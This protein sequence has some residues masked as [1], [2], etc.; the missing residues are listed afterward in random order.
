MRE[1]DCGGKQ[2]NGEFYLRLFLSPARRNDRRTHWRRHWNS[3]HIF[4]HPFSVIPETKPIAYFFS[5]CEWSRENKN[6]R[7]VVASDKTT[8]S[9][10]RG[11][12]C[13][14][15]QG[16]EIVIG[17]CGDRIEEYAGLRKVKKYKTADWSEPTE[18]HS[19][20]KPETNLQ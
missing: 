1:R 8:V 15:A 5:F 13:H 9:W 17:D 20:K 19:V 6:S 16:E 7:I 12:I 18:T 2:E 10:E 3:E 11:G 4:Q 14:E